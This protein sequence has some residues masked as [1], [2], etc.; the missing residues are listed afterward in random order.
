MTFARPPKAVRRR[1]YTLRE[2]LL[3]CA[4]LAVSTFSLTQMVSA[5]RTAEPALPRYSDTGMQ[6]FERAE[7]NFPGSAFYYLDDDAA[8]LNADVAHYDG[9]NEID[10][11]SQFAGGGSGIGP[12]APST[13]AAGSSLDKARA[14]QC[15]T[16]AIYYE[17]ALEPDAGQRA[18]AQVILNRVRHPSYPDTVCGVIYQGSERSTGCQFSFSCDGSMARAPSASYWNRAR[19]VAADAMAGMVYAR[20]GLATHYHTTQVSPYWAPSL[21]FMGTIGAHRFYRWKGAAG[22][23]SA[24]TRSYRGYEPLPA[25]NPKT[26]TPAPVADP[27]ELAREYEQARAQSK[28]QAALADAKAARQ[29]RL[30]FDSGVGA[31]PKTYAAPVYS[32]SARRNGGEQAYKASKL[33]E[34]S[35]VRDEYRTSGQWIARPGS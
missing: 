2:K 34:D 7:A 35:Q 18:V 12:A 24:F 9:N 1:R 28:R 23:K 17:A 33:P 13:K 25:P 10:A 11:A 31:P 20:A 6:P 32:D 4:V 19:R 5:Q 21:N 3:T 15:L 8:M 22:T 27:I 30:M 29:P 16:T 14:L 26:F